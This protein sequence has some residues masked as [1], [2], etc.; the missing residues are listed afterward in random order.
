MKIAVDAMG[1]DY[2]PGVVV[3]GV[4]NS[5]FEFPEFEIVL[6]GHSKKI[7]Y[8]LEKYG[9]ANHPRLQVVHADTVIEMSEPSTSSIRNKKDSSI[10][11]AA[12]L[13]K[14][15]KVDAFVTPGHTGATLAA[16]KVLVRTLPGVNRPALAANMPSQT[17]RFIVIDAGANTEVSALNLAEF[18]IMGSIYAEF[19]YGIENP[20]V[21]LL[22]VGGEDSKGND[23]TKEAFHMLE[24]APIN[25]MGNIEANTVFEG[26]CKVLVADGFTG[27][28]F[29][30]CSE[31]LAKS[32]SC[33]L[34]A[35]FTKNPLRMAGGYLNKTAFRELKDYGNPELQ[36]GAPLLGLNGVC[37]IGHGSSTPLAVKNA[38]KL[39]GE[40]I[41]FG[42]NQKI[43]DKIRIFHE[44]MEQLKN[45]NSETVDGASQN[46]QG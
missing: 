44:T 35:V 6:V 2:A 37:I 20:P 1:G 34:K 24:H 36:G 26:V 3:A 12:K 27:N 33:W 22:S 40:C 10:T 9:I 43:T 17:S 31:G 11:V 42:I 38:I 13:L 41:K 45:N 46:I 16:T 21:G 15:K 8:Y 28:V 14:E 5:L 25:F 18:A 23:L 4:A 39:A 19:M 29:L 32:V 7:A 30:K